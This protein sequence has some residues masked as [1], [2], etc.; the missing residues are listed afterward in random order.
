MT[1]SNDSYVIAYYVKKEFKG[2]HSSAFCNTTENIDD[3]K[4]YPFW[5]N[6]NRQLEVIEKNL[7]DVLSS[8]KKNRTELMGFFIM[9][10]YWNYWLGVSKDDV[11]IRPIKLN[12]VRSLSLVG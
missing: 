12:E 3:A 10:S 11:E 9:D 6:R 2:Y 1:I 7:D 5:I 4:I 8:E